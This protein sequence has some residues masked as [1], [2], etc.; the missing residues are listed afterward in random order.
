[1]RV[2]RSRKPKGTT[3]NRFASPKVRYARMAVAEFDRAVMQAKNPGDQFRVFR[4]PHCGQWHV[5]TVSGEENTV[6][7]PKD[8]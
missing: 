7:P 1:M 4:C 3:C 8:S 6:R 2:R 5:G